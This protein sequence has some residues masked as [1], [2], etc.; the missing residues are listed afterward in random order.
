MAL[1]SAVVGGRWGVT[2]VLPPN[3]GRGVPPPNG[4]AGVPP[5]NGGSSALLAAPGAMPPPAK[6]ANS[7]GWLN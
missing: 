6:D 5:P 2:G 4:G 3:G 1:Y 7:S